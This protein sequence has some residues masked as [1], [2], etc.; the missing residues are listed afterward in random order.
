M[1][2]FAAKARDRR[3]VLG[4]TLT[5][6]AAR[7]GCDAAHLANLEAGIVAPTATLVAQM[8]NAYALDRHDL[9]SAAGY[10]RFCEGTGHDS[11]TRKGRRATSPTRTWRAS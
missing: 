4:L 2:V 11:A 1:T 10:C 5:E 7:I 6:A 9:L 3:H 8:A